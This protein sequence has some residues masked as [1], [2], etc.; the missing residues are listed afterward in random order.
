MPTSLSTSPE[1]FGSMRR[2]PSSGWS[3]PLRRRGSRSWGLSRALCLASVLLLP[4]ALLA[5]CSSRDSGYRTCVRVVDGDTIVLDGRE[6]V[7]L[8][9]VDTPE[10]KDPRKPVQYFGK[11]A[12]LFTERLV[13]GRRVRLEYDQTRKDRYGRTLAYVFLQ[14]GTFVN[15]EIVR[16]GYGH[17]YTKYPF[18]R[19]D[20]FRR[21]EREARLEGLGLWAS[22]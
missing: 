19:M 6:R 14:D 8:I 5:S 11:Q 12:S 7:R 21:A 1:R 20:E 4:T 15:L 9:G 22:N 16:R 13:E 10:T 2:A 3:P 17:A 18:Q